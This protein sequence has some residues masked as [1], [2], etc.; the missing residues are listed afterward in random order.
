MNVAIQ[1]PDDIGRLLEGLTGDVSR[2][3][4]QAVAVEAYRTGAITAAQVQQMLDLPSRWAT[5]S[6]LHRSKAYLD[7]T[8]EDLE[9]DIAA[10]RDSLAQ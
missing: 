9:R 5:E 1:I 3:V 8:T 10:I 4:L 7:Y 2:A 6:F